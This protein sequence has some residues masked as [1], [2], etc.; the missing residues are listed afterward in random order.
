MRHL[1]K[2]CRGNCICLNE[3]YALIFTN[4]HIVQ[5]SFFSSFSFSPFSSFRVFF[6][7]WT[8]CF[9]KTALGASMRSIPSQYG[10]FHT[11]EGIQF[12][13]FTNNSS[14]GSPNVW[15]SAIRSQ[16]KEGTPN[17]ASNPKSS[18]AKAVYVSRRR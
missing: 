2:F 16:S 6:S 4:K 15:P 17:G 1:S 7:R 9:I 3:I 12:E 10:G 5:S 14:F 18:S 11:G 8:L 13:K